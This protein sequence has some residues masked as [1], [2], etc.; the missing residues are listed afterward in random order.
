MLIYWGGGDP[1]TQL[2][3]YYNEKYFKYSSNVRRD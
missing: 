1:E 2:V 3:R